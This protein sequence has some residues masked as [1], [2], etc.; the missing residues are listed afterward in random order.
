MV[1]LAWNLGGAVIPG[2]VGLATIPF[3]VAVLGNERYGV[4]ALAAVLFSYFLLLDLG[5][6]RALTH[7][8]AERL[9]AGNAH[10]MVSV[11]HG[12]LRMLNKLSTIGTLCVVFLTPILVD[13]F[14]DLESTR[15]IE[16]VGTIMLAVASVPFAIATG[17]WRALLEVLG[18][19]DTLNK[20]QV[21]LGTIL[22]VLPVAVLAFVDSLVAVAALLL[23]ARI[24]AL[25]VHRRIAIK[26]V[27]ELATMSAD[28]S[29][30]QRRLLSFGGWITV[31]SIVG[32]VMV[33]FDR[34]LIVGVMSLSSL[35]YYTVSYDLPTKL[36]I[37]AASVVGVTF[38]LM[39][40]LLNENRELAQSSYIVA[41][42]VVLAIISWPLATML[43]FP[44]EILALWMGPEFS[45]AGARVLQLIAVG[46]LVNSIAQVSAGV[47][48]AAGRSDW[49][50]KLHLL[51]VL[52]YLISLFFFASLWGIEGVATVWTLRMTIDAVIVLIMAGG[53]VS[54][55][56]SVVVKIIAPVL[57]IA[58]A[59]LLVG[60]SAS[61]GLRGLLAAVA[62]VVCAGAAIKLR[63]EF[64]LPPIARRES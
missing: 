25:Y 3:L 46:V 11:F 55:R 29:V 60:Q 12:A 54:M 21:P 28:H 33:Y 13:A 32:P 34:M 41:I 19:F 56:P 16:A 43:L 4:F 44:S 36:W 63:R 9:G 2:V 30:W 51:E 22:A 42:K 57:L 26:L 64:A 24:V 39:S 20:I 23:A 27:P 14:T 45:S 31:S 58:T 49:V 59:L 6:T 62:L 61:I 5:L 48:Y 40:S 7:L 37:V 1:R 10:D 50:A 47:V 38:P 8:A 52:P 15:R 17:G 53:V 18:R 35:T